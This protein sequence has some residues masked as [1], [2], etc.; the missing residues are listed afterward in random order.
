MS[1]YSLRRRIVQDTG[2][3]GLVG[4]TSSAP[5]FSLEPT[6]AQNQGELNRYI[7]DG[8][9]Y[10]CSRRPEW[11]RRSYS[12]TITAGE[13]SHVV[14]GLR[15]LD[16]VFL[17]NSDAQL[18]ELTYDTYQNLITAAAQLPADMDNATPTH[19]TWGTTDLPTAATITPAYDTD[20]TSPRMSHLVVADGFLWAYTESTYTISKYTL[21]GT[22]VDSAVLAGITDITTAKRFHVKDGIIALVS[23]VDKLLL[24]YY[25]DVLGTALAAATVPTL[26]TPC[27]VYIDDNEVYVLDQISGVADKVYVFD[28]TKGALRNFA[29]P[30]STGSLTV[31]GHEVYVSCSD[32]STPTINVY[33]STGTL[34]RTLNLAR[35]LNSVR[36]YITND[37]THL[38]L[39]KTDLVYGVDFY[40]KY[41]NLVAHTQTPYSSY[42]FPNDAILTSIFAVDSEY[43][44]YYRYTAPTAY[45][46]VRYALNWRT[47]QPNLLTLPPADD[48]YTLVLSGLIYPAPL[49]GMSDYNTLTETREDLVAAAACWKWALAKGNATLTAFWQ[50]TME[51]LLKEAQLD[52]VDDTC[53]LLEN[54]DGILE[55]ET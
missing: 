21:D 29:V 14:P 16:K 4:V 32:G 17:R 23:P 18:A 39:T 37:G 35:R 9:S 54:A 1:L 13:Y 38:C 15:R 53:R 43:A 50:G 20:F 8:I 45:E 2:D 41:G 55:V 33:S 42:A 24:L 48:A 36:D 51:V 31:L 3:Y 46:I 49:S 40:D 25:T 47:I 34:L 5:D 27:D 10:L 30:V 44:Y 19:F 7:N 26:S 28:L 52:H 22:F 6:E 12:M 11:V